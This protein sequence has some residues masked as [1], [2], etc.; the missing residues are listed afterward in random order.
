MAKIRARVYYL[1]MAA[2]VV[3]NKWNVNYHMRCGAY[4]LLI[5]IE[6]SGVEKEFENIFWQN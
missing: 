5:Q 3:Q 2:G 1:C 6:S 4:S